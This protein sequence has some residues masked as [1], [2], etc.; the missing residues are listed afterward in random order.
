[1]LVSE[2]DLNPSMSPSNRLDTSQYCSFW[3]RKSSVFL[4]VEPFS[5]ANSSFCSLYF[6]FLTWRLESYF[7]SKFLVLKPYCINS[8]LTPS[9]QRNHSLLVLD[10]H[11]YNKIV[12]TKPLRIPTY[13]SWPDDV[14]RTLDDSTAKSHFSDSYLDMTLSFSLFFLNLF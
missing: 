4:V 6:I 13:S 7:F 1:M 12:S 2:L 10:P 14:Q 3:S 5:G 9:Y 11:T 8:L